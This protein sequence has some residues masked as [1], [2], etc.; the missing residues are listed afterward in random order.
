[1]CQVLHIVVVVS[2]SLRYGLL[3]LLA[4]RPMSGYD[5]SRWFAESIANVWS[6]GHSQIYPELARLRQAGLIEVASEGGPRGRRTYAT[7]EA[8][9]EELRRWLSEDEPERAVRSEP[10]LRAFLLWLLAPEDAAGYLRREAAEHERRLRGYELK[11]ATWQPATNAEW[12]G[13]IVLEAGLRTERARLEW[14]QWAADQYERLATDQ[15][16]D[17]PAG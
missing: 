2:V 10:L 5:L 3:G 13:R 7:N 6:A 9:R 12:A 14:A 8:G 11:A 15:A 1:M 4:E 16:A 17:R